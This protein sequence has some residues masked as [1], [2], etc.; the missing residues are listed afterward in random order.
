ML[1]S[2]IVHWA[3]HA[4]IMQVL[5]EVIGVADTKGGWLRAHLLS[6]Y[7]FDQLA[8]VLGLS[9]TDVTRHPYQCQFCVQFEA[10][11]DAS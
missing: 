11:E 3:K 10:A 6:C 7:G 1:P 9:E 8:A 2:R 4:Q 5:E